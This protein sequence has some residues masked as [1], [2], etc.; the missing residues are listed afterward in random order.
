M[1]GIWILLL[2]VLMSCGGGL[3]EKQRKTLQEEM[4]AREIKKVNEED[5]VAEA[6]SLGQKLYKRHLNGSDSLALALGVDIK[7]LGKNDSTE[8]ELEWQLL[9]AYKFNLTNGGPLADNVQRDADEM[10]YTVPFTQADEFK[11]IYVLRIPRRQLV[12]NL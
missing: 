1:K 10:I 4:K 12:L 9:E 3:S 8:N 7:L 6:F 2:T 5:I 11:G